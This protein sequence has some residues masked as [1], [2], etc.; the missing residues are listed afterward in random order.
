[1][2]IPI[3][4][5]VLTLSVTAC[6][7]ECLQ[8]P[9]PLP[10]ALAV[11]VTSAN[12][13]AGVVASVAVTGPFQSTVPC[14]SSCRIPG[15]AGTYTLNVTASGYQSAERTVLVHGTSPACGCASAETEDVVFAL[16]PTP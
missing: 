9:C 14:D 3:I 16:T 7:H 4:A 13:G 12:S 8:A 5:A 1:M 11:E 6:G 2:R 15:Y 10:I